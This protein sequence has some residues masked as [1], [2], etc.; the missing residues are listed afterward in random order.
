AGSVQNPWGSAINLSVQTIDIYIDLDPGAGTGARLLLEGRNAALPA[1]FGWEYAIW[2]EG[3]NQKVLVPMSPDDP[4]SP[5]VEMSGSPL[6]IRIDGDAG[7][8]VIRLPKEILP[9]GIDPTALG[10]TLAVLSQEGYP[11]AGVRRVRDVLAI[12][13]QWRLGGAPNDVNHTRIVDMAVP[14]DIA[15][16]QESLLS[17]YEG[18][19]GRQV[20]ELNPDDFP[21]AYV[22]TAR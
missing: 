10:Y 5:P 3:W 11:S 15:V 9:D 20:D 17:D 22:N 4:A 18:I 12:A 21:A 19:T 8:I 7:K 14:V 13:G 6:K 16:S 1:E 2:V